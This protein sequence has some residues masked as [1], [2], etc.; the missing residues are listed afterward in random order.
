[1]AFFDTT[2]LGRVLN[3][4][5]SDMETVDGQ[6]GSAMVQVYLMLLATVAPHVTSHEL[7][8]NR[9]G[10]FIQSRPCPNKRKWVGCG[11]G[12]SVVQ[13]LRPLAVCVQVYGTFMNVLGALT[14]IAVVANLTSQRSTQQTI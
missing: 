4:F 6:V 12:G 14:A 11:F 5:S 7:V 1:M 9:L 3:R 13:G 8:S 2:P 10:A